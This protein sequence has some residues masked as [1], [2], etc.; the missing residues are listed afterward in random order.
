MAENHPDLQEELDVDRETRLNEPPMYRVYLVNDDYTPMDFV[1]DILMTVFRKSQENATEIMLHVHHQ[2]KGLCGVYTYEVAET[3]VDTV[4]ELA[5][6]NGY[7]L[8]S[9]M[10]NND[11]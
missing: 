7:P 6:E 2:G 10:E 8:R 1:V 9:V 3:K 4:H 5:E 11:L